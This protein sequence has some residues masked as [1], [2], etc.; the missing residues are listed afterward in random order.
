[1]SRHVNIPVFIPH[2]GCPNQC[3]FCNQRRIS[4]VNEFDLHSVTK[5]IDDALLTVEPEAECEIAFFGGS[6]TGIDRKLMIELLKIANS[7]IK[8]GRI[9]SIRCST[10]PDYIDEEILSLLK[11]YNVS[12]IELGLQSTS[13][14]VLEI[15]KRGHSFEDEMRACELIRSYGFTLGGQ[16]MIGLPSSTPEDEINTARFIV[17]SGAKEARIYPTVVFRETELCELSKAGLYTP[18]SLEEAVKRSAEVL[19][20]FI[21]ADLRIL[22]IGLCD[23]DNLHTEASYFA[24]PNHPALGELVESELYYKLITDELSKVVYN[25]AR[26]FTIGCAIGHISKVIG[27]KR[28]N[29][30]RLMNEYGFSSIKVKEDP[31]IEPFGVSITI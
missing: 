8:C 12:T 2:L 9:N 25:N 20:I 7:Y 6:F 5:I 19:E 15:T 29:K 22:R 17:S 26:S 13:D 27:Q 21:K 31:S 4:G 30:V 11:Y 24:G 28:K 14:K 18:I 23:S 10:R 1:M 3:I 16:M